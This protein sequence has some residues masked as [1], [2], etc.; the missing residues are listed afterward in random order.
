MN[1]FVNQFQ[2]ANPNQ[3]IVITCPQLHCGQLLQREQ[4]TDL[5]FPPDFIVSTTDP[6]PRK[7]VSEQKYN[8]IIWNDSNKADV[9]KSFYIFLN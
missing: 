1:E 8:W 5:S 7:P 4:E 6:T 2:S 3:M 9:L